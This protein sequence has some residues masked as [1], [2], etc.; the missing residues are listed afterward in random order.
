MS[1]PS[2]ILKS[3]K[4]RALQNRHCWLFSGAV[5]Q[6][7]TQAAEGSIVA[8]R[9]NANELLGYGFYAAQS[10]IVCRLF[11]FTNQEQEFGAA[12]WHEKINN[13]WKLRQALVASSKTTIFRL[14]HAEGDFLPGVIAD[15]FGHTIVLQILNKGAERIQHHLLQSFRLLGFEH[16]YLKNKAN[17]E[18][19]EGVTMQN[20]WLSGGFDEDLWA[21]EHGLKFKIDYLKGQKT[22]F[23]IDQREN[24]RILGQFSSGKR[25]L[26][27]F[28]YTGGFSVYAL[29]GGAR[30]VYSVDVSKDALALATENVTENFGVQAPHKVLD[31]DCFDYLRQMDENFEVIVLD[32]PAFAKS[33]RNVPN[34]A[35]GYK[36]LNRLAFNKVMPQGLILTFS[37]SQNIDKQLFRQIIFSAAAE[38]GRNVRVVEQLIQPADHP[39]NIFHPETEYLKGLMLW[40]E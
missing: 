12:Y 15:V 17:P 29:A 1:Y 11:E 4:E 8:V 21:Q 27:T 6:H 18:R 34:A 14:I 30:E 9:N 10:Q 23:F 37:C 31:S 28:S 16:I 40:V 3:G 22:G 24:R 2:I 36:D 26:N 39:I 38:A 19:L 33:A 20:G 32:P 35:R 7:P 25:V 13:A 5:K